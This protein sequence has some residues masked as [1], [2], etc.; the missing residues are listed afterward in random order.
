MTEKNIPNTYA[1]AGIDLSKEA[2]ILKNINKYVKSSFE[3]GNV[4]SKEGHYANLIKFGDY[5]LAL[6]TDGVGTKLLIAQKTG[7]FDTVGIDCVAMNVNDLLAMGI[8]PSAF[9]DYLAV[10]DFQEDVIDGIMQGILKGCELAKI[11]LI[12]GELAKIPELLSTNI[13]SFDLAGTALGI[14]DIKEIVDG[15][16]IKVGDVIIGITSSGI[17]SNGFTI[18]RKVLSIKY[19]YN[20]S[21]PW[22]TNVGE[23]LL[24]PTRIYTEAIKDLSENCEINGL[25]HITGGG[26]K[27]LFRITNLGFQIDKWCN[28]PQIFHEIQSVGNIDYQEMFSIFNMGIGFVVIVS[29]NNAQ[30]ALET[31]SKHFDSLIIGEIITDPIVKIQDYNVI[32]TR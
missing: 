32:F 22:G 16:K 31:L 3:L 17:H 9:V 1:E 13:N 18:L 15:S 14:V 30:K 25:A 24:I 6:A 28:I 2:R 11:P 7:K 26:F 21:F 12:G 10:S 20:E 5:G 27:K 8:Q 23:E 29:K 19:E 4:V